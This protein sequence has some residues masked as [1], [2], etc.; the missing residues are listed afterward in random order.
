MLQILL[1][2]R[3]V[4][5]AGQVL[6]IVFVSQRLGLA[7][8]VGALLTVS[9]GLL[10][11]NLAMHAW[12]L[13]TRDARP[14]VLIVHLL[15]D[16]L[17]LTGLLYF[18]GGPGNP[19]VS[20]YLVP[21]ALAAIGLDLVPM[22]M[23]TV[24]AGALYT[25]LLT[26]HVPLPHVHDRDF[27]LHVTG[28][29]INF[30]LTAVIM[31]TVLARFMAVVREQRQRLLHIRENS[32]RDESLLAIGSLAAGTAH[33][34]NTPLTTMGLLL[35]DWICEDQPPS[36]DDIEMMRSQ[37]T[38]CRDHVRALTDIAR[39]GAADQNRVMN[40]DAFVRESIDRWQLLR[41]NVLVSAEYNSGGQRIQVAVSLSQAVLNLLNNAAD[42]TLSSGRSEPIDVVTQVKRDRL[43]ILIA[44]RGPGPENIPDEPR[45]DHRGP[46]LGIGLMVSNASIERSRGRVRQFARQGGGCV[47]QIELPLAEGVA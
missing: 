19:F 36:R 37:L 23:L 24:A 1:Y 45:V 12:W 42:A 11:F 8:P 32:L 33:E 14:G 35:D 27:E 26:H 15:A 46:G 6:T 43:E 22:I 44:D 3:Y 39:R 38:H 40:A 4:A 7:I 47:T 17:A 34:L 2:L 9:G 13:R 29:W 25:W 28:M 10:V 41:P 18:S 21:V 20:L 31:A 30:M 5:V 16:M